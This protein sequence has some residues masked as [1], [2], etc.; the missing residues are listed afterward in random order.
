MAAV[1]FLWRKYRSKSTKYI[2]RSDEQIVF[3]VKRHVMLYNNKEKENKEKHMISDKIEK[4]LAYAS[5]IRFAKEID[6]FCRTHDLSTLSE[7]RH[8]IRGNELYVNVQYAVTALF[9]E[10]EWESHK[11]YA[12]L[13]LVISGEE[14]FGC[15]EAPL[16]APYES[17]PESDIFLYRI[18]P[19]PITLLRLTAGEFIYFAPGEQHAPC[20]A[21]V[22][23]MRIKKAVFKI[24]TDK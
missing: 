7:G 8:E 18:M 22:A 21:A 20:C 23:P 16:P 11:R 10:R 9:R 3:L 13:Q 17:R 15:C 14:C 19:E 1:L 12:D 24:R 6:E 4:V 2:E 5:E